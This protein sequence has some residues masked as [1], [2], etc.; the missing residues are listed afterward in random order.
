MR[1]CHDVNPASC[2]FQRA[3]GLWRGW[4]LPFY[5]SFGHCLPKHCSVRVSAALLNVLLCGFIL[6]FVATKA[7]IQSSLCTKGPPEPCRMLPAL[8]LC[9]LSKVAAATVPMGLCHKIGIYRQY[10]PQHR[11]T[12]GHSTA[13]GT[14][15]P[16]PKCCSRTRMIY[17]H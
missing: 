3:T 2:L 7:I 17:R 13:P 9:C 10:N 11:P 5:F 14:A 6:P 12:A 16:V 8:L 4:L 15:E 1:V